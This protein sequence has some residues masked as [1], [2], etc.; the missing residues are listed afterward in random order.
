MGLASGLAGRISEAVRSWI[1]TDQLQIAGPYNV[2]IA[3]TLEALH[4]HLAA[5]QKA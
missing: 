3:T 5:L 1:R 4:A 2:Q